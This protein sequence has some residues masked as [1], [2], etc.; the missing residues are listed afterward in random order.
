MATIYMI[1]LVYGT[2]QD[3]VRFVTLHSGTVE[4]IYY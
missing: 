3:T 2:V 1:R 4:D